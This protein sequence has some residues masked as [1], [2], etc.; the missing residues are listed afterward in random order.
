VAEEL[1]WEGVRACRLSV[2]RVWTWARMTLGSQN[3]VGSISLRFVTAEET[4]TGA[5][6]ESLAGCSF[7]GLVFFD[8]G[9]SAPLCYAFGDDTRAH[10]N[11]RFLYKCV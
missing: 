9:V 1:R 6:C 7:W 5:V 8:S 10:L 11:S 2:C 3:R 4:G